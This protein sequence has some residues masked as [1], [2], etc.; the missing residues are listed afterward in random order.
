MD[1]QGP[2]DKERIVIKNAREHNL[3]GID[4]E[5]P[6][7]SLVTFSGISGSGKSSL[8]FDTIFQE[9]QRRFLESLSPYARQFLGSMRKPD[10]E[11]I[12]GLSPTIAI[13][14]RTARGSR[15]STVGTIT[16]LQDLLRLL[17]A[18]LGEPHCPV[19]GVR[20]S[21]LSARK[22]AEMVIDSAGGEKGAEGKPAMVFILAPVVYAR[23]GEHRVV[24]R[25]LKLKGIV[26]ARID[27]Q[28]VRLDRD[29]NL[30]RY[31]VHTIEALVDRIRPSRERI[32]RVTE[33]I[34]T[35][36]SLSEGIVTFHFEDGREETLS[37]KASCPFGHGS[38]PELEPRLFSFNSPLGACP[39]C[40]G[41]GEIREFTEKSLIID[42]KKSILEGALSC[43]TRF[44]SIGCRGLRPEDFHIVGRYFGFD[45][46]KPWKELPARAR[47]RRG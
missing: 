24:L 46:G 34:E 23:K 26:R 19:C 45:I 7:N 20:I 28:I 41:L 22:M 3:K 15:R 44:G 40:E 25:S 10:V 38:L 12:E 43:L 27:G 39:R 29:I 4:L 37:S 8:V 32:S 42:P 11:S 21:P 47:R 36:L 16:G 2:M 30:E 9:G 5:I 18:R 1:S 17:F 35:A 33:S 6:K 14:Q 31:K 13:D